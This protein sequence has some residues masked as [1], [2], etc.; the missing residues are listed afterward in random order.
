LVLRNPLDT[1]E[2]KTPGT[3][4]ANIFSGTPFKPAAPPAAPGPVR[5]TPRPKPVA[6]AAVQ[7]ERVSIP[8]VVEIIQGTRKNEVKF[9]EQKDQ[10]ANAEER[11]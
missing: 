2:A 3:A 7:P 11:K 9:Q 1:K 5:S 6:I 4:S 8:V 10:P